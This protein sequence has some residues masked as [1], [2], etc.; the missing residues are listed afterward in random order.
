MS[1]ILWRSTTNDIPEAG[2][3]DKDLNNQLQEELEGQTGQAT[4]DAISDKIDQKDVEE[5][6]SEEKLDQKLRMDGTWKLEDWRRERS[7]LLAGERDGLRERTVED[8]KDLITTIYAD[9]T[10]SRAAAKT[11]EEL[12]KRNGEG[13][14]KVC[15][16][17]KSLR[18]KV[19]EDKT[20]YM[21]LATQGI[22]RRDGPING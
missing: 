11:L 6:S 5:S 16:Q 13:L 18:L 20:V 2:L 7:G 19:N 15:N 22:R 14:T 8:P 9:D 12:E 21:V 1:P 4:K 17:L 3:V 10:Q